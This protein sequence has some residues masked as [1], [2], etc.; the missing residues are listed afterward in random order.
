MP[1]SHSVSFLHWFLP[2]SPSELFVLYLLLLL[3]LSAPREAQAANK[4]KVLHIIISY[5]NSS[6]SFSV[7]SADATFASISLLHVILGLPLAVRL[8][9]FHVPYLVVFFSYSQDT[10]QSPINNGLPKSVLL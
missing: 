2:R 5:A 6:S 10:P 1:L 9:E 7:F 8:C 4:L 3:R